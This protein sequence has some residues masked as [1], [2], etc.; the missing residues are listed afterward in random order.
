MIFAV[1]GQISWDRKK[2]PFNG[3]HFLSQEEISCH[4]KA[5]PVTGRK[6]LSQEEFSSNT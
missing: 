3:R 1:T 5:F 4:R 6:L 2:F